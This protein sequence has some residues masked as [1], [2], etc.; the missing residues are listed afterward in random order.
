MPT[1]LHFLFYFFAESI[2]CL[3]DSVFLPVHQ[4][5][6]LCVTWQSDLRNT[7]TC[8][9]Q[10]IW[11]LYVCLPLAA[12]FH[13]LLMYFLPPVNCALCCMKLLKAICCICYLASSSRYY[14]P[15]VNKWGATKD[16]AQLK[17]FIECFVQGAKTAA[18]SV[19][20]FTTLS[21]FSLKFLLASNI[22]RLRKVI[23]VLKRWEHELM[24]KHF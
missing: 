19:R 13:P 23:C 12:H 4:E 1:W 22:D 17:V 7:S 10:F 16:L 14:F 24:Y 20:S 18:A 9:T 8:T 2:P 5:H 3:V 21:I 6:L 11:Q 15:C